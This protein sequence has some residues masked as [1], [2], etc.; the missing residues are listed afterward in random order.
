MRKS[1]SFCF[2]LISL[3]AAPA[4]QAGKLVCWT[5]DKG[6]RACGDRVPP[7]YAKG[8]RQVLDAHGRVVQKQGRQKTEAEVAEEE[9]KAA[10]VIAEKERF[11][12][13]SKDDR[14]LLQTFNTPQD[15]EQSRDSRLRAL[16]AQIVLNDKS[17]ADSEKT[18]KSLQER[19]AQDKKEGKPVDASLEKQIRQFEADI[20]E[21]RAAREQ[22]LKDQ[23]A[24]KSKFGNDIE[25]FNKLKSR[26][27]EIG[28]AAT[29]EAGPA[30]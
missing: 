24:I 20:A 21:S 29:A 22:K 14:F 28:A 26:Q 5:D 16:N 3:A 15:L 6:Q 8:E 7:Q 4:A 10:A 25:R 13:Q 2:L 17:I 23:A 19:A 11:E 12:K 18:L 1:I 27:I 9:R 30:P